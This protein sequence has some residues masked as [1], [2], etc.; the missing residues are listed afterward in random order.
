MGKVLRGIAIILMPQGVVLGAALLLVYCAAYPHSAA[1][2]TVARSAHALI[3]PGAKKYTVP[4]I[5]QLAVTP[6]PPPHSAPPKD[7]VLGAHVKPAVDCDSRPC[8]ALSFDDGPDAVTTPR[9]LA[10]LETKRIAA[11]FFLI[12]K[13]IGGNEALVRR[14]VADRFEIGNHTWSHPHLPALKKAKINDEVLRTQTA[15]AAT[16]APLPTLLRPPYG[17]IDTAVV[18]NIGLQVALWNEDPRDWQATSHKALV[19]AVLKAAKPG[20]VIDFHDIHPI[21]ADVLPTI[22]DKL[23][24]RHYQFVTVSELLHSRYRP[25]N[26]PFYGYAATP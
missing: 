4:S 10:T 5:D 17:D 19:K 9:V 13:N 11:T 24:A 20:G 16:G 22:I 3:T 26:A 25:G 15:I 12:G 8:I 21:T 6:K 2:I 1:P 18:R 23:T 14:M 7:G